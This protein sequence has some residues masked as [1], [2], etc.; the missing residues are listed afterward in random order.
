MY[1]EER[2]LKW[3]KEAAGYYK[4]T[5]GEYWV[6]NNYTIGY[7]RSWNLYAKDESV[8]LCGEPDGVVDG[9]NTKWEAQERAEELAKYLQTQRNG[10]AA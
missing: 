2:K 9:F 1:A 8:T 4:T 10:Q 5:C 7:G 3:K 6:A